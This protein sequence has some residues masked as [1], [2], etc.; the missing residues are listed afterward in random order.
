MHLSL[1]LNGRGSVVDVRPAWVPGARNGA[2]SRSARQQS[3][4]TEKGA[5]SSAYRLQRFPL[6][7]CDDPADVVSGHGH[8]A[9]AIR[10][11]PWRR[12]AQAGP[13]VH[14]AAGIDRDN[15]AVLCPLVP[16]VLG[17]HQGMRCEAT[18]E[19]ELVERVLT[20]VQRIPAATAAAKDAWISSLRP[21]SL[22]ICR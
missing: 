2:S 21:A 9:S 14:G 17:K 15:D 16:I 7:Y 18:G 11:P 3:I 12:H 4:H 6:A 10:C 22:A 5:H 20:N 19:A 13:G 1:P 8:D